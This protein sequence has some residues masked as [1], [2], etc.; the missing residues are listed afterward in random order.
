MYESLTLYLGVSDYRVEHCFFQV[1]L[2][3][4]TASTI[5]RNHNVNIYTE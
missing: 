2:G 5:R 1:F 4:Q 3:N